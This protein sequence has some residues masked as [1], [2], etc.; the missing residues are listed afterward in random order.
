MKKVLVAGVLGALAALVQAGPAS[1]EVRCVYW[2]GTGL[3]VVEPFNGEQ[4][5]YVPLYQADPHCLD[6]L[7]P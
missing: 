3:H 4:V 1:A 5:A 6:H 2:G 7:L